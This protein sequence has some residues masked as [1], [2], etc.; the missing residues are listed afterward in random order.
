MPAKKAPSPAKRRGQGAMR[1]DLLLDP[2]KA[3]KDIRLTNRAIREGWPVTPE[4]MQ[5]S[6]ERLR[7]IVNKRTVKKWHST[8]KGLKQVKDEK[9]ADD[10]AISAAAV[11]VRAA[12]PTKKTEN[13]HNF[14]P[15]VVVGVSRADL[16][17]QNADLPPAR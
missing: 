8:P 2:K 3:K 4:V 15:L 9:A 12:P 10:N 13:D 11:L 5:E 16:R 14:G 1:S 17:G 6:V 7:E